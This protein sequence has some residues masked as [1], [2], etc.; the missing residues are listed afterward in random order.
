MASEPEVTPIRNDPPKVTTLPDEPEI[1]RTALGPETTTTHV[2]AQLP[3]ADSLGKTLTNY[4]DIAA[5]LAI[6]LVVIVVTLWVK[7]YLGDDEDRTD[8]GISR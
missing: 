5:P 7:R 1:P 6:A 8:H 2:S 4:L 3:S